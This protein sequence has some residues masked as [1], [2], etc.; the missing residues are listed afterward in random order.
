MV[1][2]V[3]KSERGSARD[4]AEKSVM[5]VC[6]RI[7]DEDHRAEQLLAV[8]GGLNESDQTAMLPTLGRV[9]TNAGLKV[10]A[11]AIADSVPGRHEGGLRA[12]CNW[13]DASV[14]PRLIE[15]AKSDPHAN[16]RT[17][18][19]RALIRVAPLPDERTDEEK[20]ALLQTAMGMCGRDEERKLV[21]NR[22]R[23]I[24]T[25][26]SLRFILPYLDKP[27]Y[28]QT[29]AESVVELAH[30]RDLREPNR[31]EFVKALDKVIQTSQDA[32]VIDRANRYKKDQTWVRPSASNRP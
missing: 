32:T 3:L 13:P 14:A 29:A 1:Q 17:A 20:L 8:M 2:G 31:T 30:H 23:A 5:A 10:V 12:L 15:L 28:A 7:E 9:G 11:E 4:S 24:R 21:L 18:A 26:E 16:H 22:A 27:P 6:E 19:L 25:L